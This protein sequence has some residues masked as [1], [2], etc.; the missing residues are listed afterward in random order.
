[1]HNRNDQCDQRANKRNQGDH[2]SAPFFDCKWYHVLESLLLSPGKRI[3]P[4]RT[5]LSACGNLAN[6]ASRPHSDERAEYKGPALPSNSLCR[7]AAEAYN[8]RAVSPNRKYW[9]CL[10]AEA[11]RYIP[12]ALGTTRRWNPWGISPSCGFDRSSTALA[13]S[14]HGPRRPVSAIDTVYASHW[15]REVSTFSH[16]TAVGRGG[17]TA[18]IRFK[19]IVGARLW[20]NS[21][22]D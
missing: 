18:P 7:K 16:R 21:V 11:G 5:E 6:S 2:R 22:E 8:A 13:E 14:F 3:P 1:M 9:L 10:L 20:P 17:M 15:V 19:V 4:D 12:R